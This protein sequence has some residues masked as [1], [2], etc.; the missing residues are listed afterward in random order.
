M[1]GSEKELVNSFKNLSR[2]FLDDVSNQKN[3]RTFL[4]Q[5]FDSLN[6]VADLVLGTY[7][8]YLNKKTARQPIDFNWVSPL[9]QL[10]VG[11]IISIEDF[12]EAYSVAKSTASR[13]LKDYCNA[14]FLTP[15]QKN[16]YEV[17]KQYKPIVETIISIEAKLKN[18]QRALQQACRY[19][20]FSNYSFVLLEEKYS[21]PAIKNI[22]SFHS[23]GIGLITMQ[24][25]EY[26][27][28]LIPDRKESNSSSS[29]YRVNEVAFAAVTNH[30]TSS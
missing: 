2:R 27:L 8:P 4:L 24:G 3:S 30:A 21:N 28:H 29:F 23:F 14:R 5:E 25:N 19:R 9:V 20:N 13:I 18:W 6:G 10:N 17:I 12:M 7:Q 11:E 16:K 22:D 15:I 26:K 1:Y